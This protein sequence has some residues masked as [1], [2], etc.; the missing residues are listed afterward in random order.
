MDA[1]NDGDFLERVPKWCMLLSRDYGNLN[2]AGESNGKPT[3]HVL[4]RAITPRMPWYPSDPICWCKVARSLGNC[5]LR[6]DIHMMVDGTAARDVAWNFIERWNWSMR[7]VRT[8]SPLVGL[9]ST[10]VKTAKHRNGSGAQ[11]KKPVYLLPKYRDSARA[12]APRQPLPT[13]RFGRFFNTHGPFSFHSLSSSLQLSSGPNP[14]GRCI[15]YYFYSC[16][17][18]KWS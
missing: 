17:G 5:P 16:Y 1:T 9:F 15:P 6:H 4:Q 8:H 13:S 7:Y 18:D 10:Y 11:L 3:D 12:I 2:Y 14:S